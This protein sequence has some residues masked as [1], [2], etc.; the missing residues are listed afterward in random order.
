M[1]V[2]F[3]HRSVAVILLLLL[4]AVVFAGHRRGGHKSSESTSS[5][6]HSS[7]SHSASDS[8]SSEMVGS[9]TS[10]FVTYYHTSSI[11]FNAYSDGRVS[12]SKGRNTGNNAY[13]ANGCGD[14]PRKCQDWLYR[15][16]DGSCNNLHYPTWGMS[17]TRYARIAH[18]RYADGISTPRRSITGSELPLSRLLS[19]TVFKIGN[20]PDPL[21]TLATMQ[22]GQIVSHDMALAD[23]T[24]Q[25]KAHE[26]RCC[27]DNGRHL[28][29]RN[30]NERCYPIMIPKNDSVYTPEGI[31]CQSFVRTLTDIGRG[32]GS[33]YHDGSAEQL[34][35][36]TA[37]MDASMVYGSD[38]K[39]ARSLRSFKG[40]ELLT[41]IR[42]NIE[43]MPS[44]GNKSMTCDLVYA[45]EACYRAGDV[46]VNQ[47]PQLTVLQELY[48]KEHNRIART[49]KK[50]N[51][52]WTDETIYQETRKIVIAEHQQIT[53]YEWLPILLGGHWLREIGVLAK[54]NG[55][56]D[57]YLKNISPNI[58]NEHS[59]AAFRYFHTNIPDKIWLPAK[60]T[61]LRLSDYFNRPG[62]IEGNLPDLVAG[63]SMQPQDYTDGIFSAEIINYLFRNRKRVGDDL[64]A[65][66]IQRNRDHGLASY[67]D[68]RQICGLKRAHSFDDFGDVINAENLQH[69][70]ALYKSPEDVDLIVGGH[71]ET[72]VK[73]TLVGPTYRC[74]IGE[75][76]YRTRKSDRYWYEWP[77]GEKGFTKE[78]LN[79]IRKMTVAK[80]FC[81]NAHGIQ[82]MQPSA[83]KKI[84]RRNKAVPCNK[85]PGINLMYWK[86]YRCD[87][88]H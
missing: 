44:A 60:N 59:T 81:D 32:C 67:N 5:E 84:S 7:E 63:Q 21:W 9:H 71:M 19:T 37:W 72:H 29:T 25:S 50:L 77:I 15:T 61:Y 1:R 41:E 64:L 47:N 28:S 76:F 10:S 27:T 39:T 33:V 87:K 57:S 18:P 83:F 3:D 56:V 52:C 88:K 16:H 17:T 11:P 26:I 2:R 30:W 6:S 34:N 23:G 55:H 62:V 65:T 13:P 49:L 78:Q 24:T 51:P 82:Y 14:L 40:G 43:Y 74:I 36:V 8:N 35:A 75:Q 79:E 46:R 20:K 48:L 86:D 68:L 73:G 53:Y 70:K 38:E 66:D 54:T 4:P 45:N 80:F 42:N 12:T 58:L 22:W 85:I 31:V 69:L